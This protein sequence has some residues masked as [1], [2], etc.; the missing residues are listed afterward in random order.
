MIHID[1][2]TTQVTGELDEVLSD[3][4]NLLKLLYNQLKEIF[5]EDKAKLIFAHMGKLAVA[6]EKELEELKG[7]IGE[8][9]NHEN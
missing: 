6:D 1:K 3:T 8:I 9:F 4:T 5:N 7:K 2:R